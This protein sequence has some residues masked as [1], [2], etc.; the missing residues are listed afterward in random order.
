MAAVMKRKSWTAGGK[1][2]AVI[3]KHA[4]GLEFFEVEKQKKKKKRKRE[5]QL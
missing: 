4:D 2:S 5:Q 1:I 3:V